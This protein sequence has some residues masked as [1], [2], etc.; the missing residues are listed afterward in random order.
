[1]KRSILIVLIASLILGTIVPLGIVWARVSGVLP[2]GQDGWWT[3]R[4]S[5][6]I[7]GIGGTVF[8]LLGG[9]IGTLGGCGIARRF[10][11]T[12]T[13]TVAG[14]GVVILIIGVIALALGQPYAVYYPLLLCG[15]LLPGILI[16]N[17]FGLRWAYEQRELR[18]MAAM[19]SR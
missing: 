16:P 8:G 7:G 10:V 11:L 13:A 2:Q 1:M 3:E 5:G 14:L 6:W 17:F 18:K 9:L 19:D 4:D 12:L 15:I